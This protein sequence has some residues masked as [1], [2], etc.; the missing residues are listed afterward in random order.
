MV[1]DYVVVVVV[2]VFVSSK[3]IYMGLS[4]TVGGG[5]EFVYFG[6]SVIGDDVDQWS[7]G[8]VLSSQ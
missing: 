5:F 6:E 3:F 1:C 4:V 8:F 2:V 7:L